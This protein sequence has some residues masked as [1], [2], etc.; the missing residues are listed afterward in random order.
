MLLL[1]LHQY[2]TYKR[3]DLVFTNYGHFWCQMRK[4]CV[5]KLFSRRRVKSWD[6]V[7]EQVDSMVRTI[8]DSIDSEVNI[9]ELMFGLTRGII[10]KAAFGTRAMERQQEFF[11]ILQEFSKLFGAFNITDFVPWLRWIHLKLLSGRLVVAHRL[12]DYFVDK[13]I[14]DHMLQKKEHDRINNGGDDGDE[15]D[16]HGDMV[17][18]LLTFYFD[19]GNNNDAEAIKESVDDLPYSIKLTRDN[20]KGIIMVRA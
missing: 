6:L 8:T 9:R 5:M 7:R 19:E 12:M 11:E 18:S 13:I 17:D 2:L 14:D 20:I 3:A 15:A 10:Y 4:L 16:D 1:F